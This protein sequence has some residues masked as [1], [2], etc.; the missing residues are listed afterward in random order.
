[1]C[2]SSHCT[3]HTTDARH[4]CNKKNDEIKNHHKIR[5]I[6]KAQQNVATQLKSIWESQKAGG[7]RGASKDP[8]TR[9]SVGDQGAGKALTDCRRTRKRLEAHPVE[10]KRLGPMSMWCSPGRPRWAT[11]QARWAAH[12][13]RWTP[14]GHR[15]RPHTGSPFS[16]RQKLGSRRG[17][18]KQHP[19]K[20]SFELAIS[21]AGQY[22]L[23]TILLIPNPHSTITIDNQ[24]RPLLN[25]NECPRVARRSP[26][27]TRRQLHDRH[28]HS[29]ILRNTLPSLTLP[30]IMSLCPLWPSIPSP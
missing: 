13:A 27:I 20:P 16:H 1:M 26:I 29:P 12:S 17:T 9:N 24:E 7:T 11:S 19:P 14:R 5:T 28:L 3:S 2:L 4:T 22:K 21:Y 15:L 10:D 8:V 23:N 6:S 30:Q 25:K 18:A